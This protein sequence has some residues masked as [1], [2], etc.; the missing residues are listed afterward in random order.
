MEMGTDEWRQMINRR[1]ELMR[2]KCQ[3]GLTAEEQVEYEHLRELSLKVLL[4]MP[5]GFFHKEYS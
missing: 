5:R 3:D 2:K 4:D 1:I